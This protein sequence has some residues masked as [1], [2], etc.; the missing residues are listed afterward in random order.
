MP[1]SQIPNVRL[2]A[3]AATV[4]A[5]TLRYAEE[6]RALN[7]NPAQAERIAKSIGLVERRVA[8]PDQTALDL[9]VH[10][11]E[12]L[13]SSF[14]SSSLRANVDGLIFVTQSPDHFQPC[15]AAIAHGRLRLREDCAVFDV[16]LGCSG[17]VYGLWL[18]HQLLTSGG[19][20]NVLL[21]AGDTLSK[22][23]RSDDRAVA[24]LFGD[25]GTASLLQR[26]AGNPSAGFLLKSEG[27]GS[28]VIS[29]PGGGYRSCASPD[30]PAFLQ[31][32]GAEVFNFSL[33]VAAPTSQ[34]LLDK[35]AVSVD[36]VDAFFFHQANR[37]I[38]QSI[39]RKLKLTEAKAPSDSFSKFGNTSSA[40]IPLALCQDRQI[41]PARPLRRVSLCGFGVGLSWGAA[42]LTLPDSLSCSL[43]DLA[44]SS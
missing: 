17:Y 40:S 39:A 8:A 3:V 36:S 4:P 33:R 26:C 38:V 13:L 41:N 12:H 24:P 5:L 20:E 2:S 6:A 44:A 34:E 16:G 43:L 9:C 27:A 37:F 35:M 21:L 42:L 1:F 30:S 14:D 19:C 18:A 7:E 29:I 31:M 10:S 11:A 23:V 15:N 22:A 32:D 28:S 25:A